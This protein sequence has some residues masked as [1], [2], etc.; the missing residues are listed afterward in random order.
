MAWYRIYIIRSDN[1][2]SSDIG[3]ECSDDQ[4]A[5]VLAKRLLTPR[6]QAEV[7]NGTK[8]VRVL[9]LSMAVQ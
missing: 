3:A 8:L 5:C 4:Q 2:S 1:L 6:E 9:S 7:W